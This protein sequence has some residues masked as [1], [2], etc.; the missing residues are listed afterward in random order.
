MEGYAEC[1][2]LFDFQATD[3]IGINKKKIHFAECTPK[4]F[5]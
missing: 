1:N 4:T 5:N 2:K 3:T